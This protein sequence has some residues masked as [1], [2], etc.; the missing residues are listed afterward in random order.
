MTSSMDAA[1]GQVRAPGVAFQ[2]AEG[3]VWKNRS[4]LLLWIAQAISQTAQNAIWYGMMVLVQSKSHSATHM[5]V[6][7]MTLIVPS[8]LFGIIAGAYVDR[9]DKRLV[10]IGSNG[11]RAIVTLGYVCFSDLLALVYVVNFVFSTIG[12]FFG[13]AESAMIPSIVSKRSLLQANSLFHLTFTASQLLGLVLLGPVVVNLLGVHGLFWL[14][15]AAFAVCALLVWPLPAGY[16]AAA[17]D[18]HGAQTLSGL[19]QDVREVLVYV[20][21][22]STVRMAVVQWNL[23]AALGIVIAMLAPSF[24]EKVLG[25][26]PE[27]SVLVL[28]P[29]GV[30]MV[31]ATIVLTRAGQG[32]DRHALTNGGLMVVA[33][34]LTALGL[35]RPL[36]NVLIGQRGLWFAPPE[37]GLEHGVSLAVMAIALIAGAGFV[38]IIV[39][40]QTLIQERVPD[41]IRGRVFAVQ[42]VLSNVVSILPLVFLGSI[43]DLIGV[44][45]TLALLGGGL[46]VAG[47]WTVRAHRRLDMPPRA[48]LPAL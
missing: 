23:G 12:Q 10:L 40:S 20:R 19:W 25:I 42:L 15:A 46:F 36:A 29:A 6:A 43:A 5:S 18:R 45:P 22:D 35:I 31:T 14:V 24:V 1:S 41:E 37:G 28:A 48:G 47:G 27:E 9:W 3:P 30:G 34:A 17:A 32:W 39:P 26:R 38:T 16:G 2:A 33:A 44:G 13:P 11:L 8:V 7:I 4:F 21:A